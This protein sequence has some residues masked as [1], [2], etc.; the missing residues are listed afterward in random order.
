M[1]R[2][3]FLLEEPSMKEVL[4]GLLPRIFPNLRFLCIPHEG[5]KDLDQ[6]ILHKL[7]DWRVPG[8]HFVIVRDNDGGD[9]FALKRRLRDLCQQTGHED[10][11][12]RIVCQEL[13]A[14]YLGEPG[15][16]AAAFEDTKLNNIGNRPIY[17]NP[18]QRCKPSDDL[19]RLVPDFQKTAGARVMANHL[20]REGNRSHSFKVFLDGVERLHRPPT[21]S[22]EQTA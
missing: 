10:V 17:R 7:R 6:S 21:V 11:L 4:E 3:V 19:A 12:I 9:C 14:W 16:L 18:D 22:Q 13:E 2:F 15:A 8:D 1:G 5:K 20:T